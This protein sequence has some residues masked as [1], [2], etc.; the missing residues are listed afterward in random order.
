MQAFSR[1]SQ[2]RCSLRLLTVIGHYIDHLGVVEQ[3]DGLNN[4]VEFWTNRSRMG[5]IVHCT[6]ST[7]ADGA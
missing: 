7:P 6:L 2:L 3:N 4:S 5:G 1:M